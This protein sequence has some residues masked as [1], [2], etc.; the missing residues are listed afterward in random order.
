M[1]LGMVLGGALVLW[2]NHHG[3]T[4][5]GLEEMAGKFNL[6]SRVYPELSAIGLLLG[7]MIV[8]VSSVAAS[9]YPAVRLHWM[10]PV[11]AM[12]AA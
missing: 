4:Y 11:T 3:F 6:P 1:F 5:P 8:L 7:P 10:E 12:R 9:V 2:L